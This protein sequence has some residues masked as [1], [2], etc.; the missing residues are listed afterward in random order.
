MQRDPWFIEAC[1]ST[2]NPTAPGR[3]MDFISSAVPESARI[4]LSG[5]EPGASRGLGGDRFQHRLALLAKSIGN[6]PGGRM[7]AN[8]RFDRYRQDAISLLS[9][10]QVHRALDVAMPS[11]GVDRY[12]RNVFGWSLLMAK[13]LVASGVS[14]VQV[15]LGQQRNLGYAPEH[16]PGVERSIISPDRSVQF[17]TVGRLSA[18]GLIDSTL[19]VM[20][21]EFGRTPKIS[22]CPG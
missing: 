19:I 15:N 11:Q 17:R 9:D 14:L 8:E 12:G 20:A 21:G 4:C 18:E 7:A 5:A 16:V 3:S 13:R 6:A 2:P 10:S 1:R 22:T